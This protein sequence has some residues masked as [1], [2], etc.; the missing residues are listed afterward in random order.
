M[1]GESSHSL[2]KCSEASGSPA[3][4]VSILAEDQTT[5]LRSQ[6]NSVGFG[7]SAGGMLFPYYIGVVE[8]L[9]QLGHIKRGTPMAGSS[10]GALIVAAF[11]A[12]VPLS[13][14]ARQTMELMQDCGERGTRFRIGSQIAKVIDRIL[15]KDAY[16]SCRGTTFISVTCMGMEGEESGRLVTDF[17]SNDDLKAA[18]LTSCHCPVWFDGRLWTRFRGVASY[19]GGVHR[20]IPVPPV[21]QK[22]VRVCCF[23]SK[24][25][26]RFRSKFPGIQISM[27]HLERDLLMQWT[28]APADQESLRWLMEMGRRDVVQ[29]HEGLQGGDV[30]VY[31]SEYNPEFMQQNEWHPLPRV[32]PRAPRYM[33]SGLSRIVLGAQTSDGCTEMNH[34]KKPRSTALQCASSPKVQSVFSKSLREGFQLCMITIFILYTDIVAGYRRR[35]DPLRRTLQAD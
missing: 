6:Q 8:M 4:Q 2:L 3:L 5:D 35:R 10:A 25:N 30:G 9:E 1:H 15:P 27:E 23:P 7:F 12:G 21:C 32:C 24:N 20:F 22:V 28:L 34:S 17:R 11:N 33:Q 13:V 29:W 16:L 14:I 31:N 26:N 19:D 18:V